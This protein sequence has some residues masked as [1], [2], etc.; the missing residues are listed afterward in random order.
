MINTLEKLAKLR[1]DVFSTLSYLGNSVPDGKIEEIVLGTYKSQKEMLEKI[2]DEEFILTNDQLQSIINDVKKD[3]YV[4]YVGDISEIDGK[5]KH[6]PW[7]TDEDRYNWKYFQRYKNR[8]SRSGLPPK[9][10]TKMDDWTDTILNKINNPNDEGSW[11]RRGLVVGHVQSGKTMN[12]IGLANK[13]LDKGYK[14]IIILAGRTNDLRSQ[15]QERC[16]LDI[17]GIDTEKKVDTQR[18]VP[19]GVGKDSNEKLNSLVVNYLTTMPGTKTSKNI[20]G[21][22]NRS[23]AKS[24]GMQSFDTLV[25]V[26]KKH[27]SILRDLLLWVQS[28]A[29]VNAPVAVEDTV[30]KDLKIK[31]INAFPLLLIDD[32]CDD[33]SVDSTK[34]IVDENNQPI[35]DHDPTKTNRLIRQ[36]LLSFSKSSYIGYTATP[37]AN[38]FIHHRGSSKEVGDDLFPR[39]FI[40]SLPHPDN[41]IGANEIF[42]S[43]NNYIKNI[44]DHALTSAKRE[45]N[46]WMP[47]KHD[48][49]H[50]PLYKDKLQCPPSLKEA[51]N[52]FVLATAGIKLRHY[53][54]PEHTSML[55]HV[56]RFRDVQEEV[57]QQVEDYFFELRLSV[58]NETDKD[59]NSLMK[60]LRLQWEDEFQKNLN[61]ENQNNYRKLKWE[62]IYNELHK[63]ISKIKL[64]KLN[65]D[66]DDYL[67]YKKNKKLGLSV[68]AIGGDRLSRGVTLEGLC[69]TYFLRAPFTHTADTLTQ[70]GRWY[71]YRNG[72]EDLCRVYM[73]NRMQRS[74]VSFAEF[75]NELR[76]DLELMETKGLT[77]EDFGFIV[78]TH[79]G[80]RVTG[81]SRNAKRI[82]LNY[83]GKTKQVRGINIDEDQNDFNCN[84]INKLYQD[85]MTANYSFKEE[86][87]LMWKDVES[88]FI[89]EFLESYKDAKGSNMRSDFNAKYIKHRLLETSRSELKKWTVVIRSGSSSENIK[90]D[91]FTVNLNIRSNRSIFDKPSRVDDYQ[92]TPATGNDQF[93]GLEEKLGVRGSDSGLLV[94][95]PIAY[96]KNKNSKE[97]DDLENKRFNAFMISY[98]ASDYNDPGFEMDVNSV[99]YMQWEK[100]MEEVS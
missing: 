50:K 5:E 14:F 39:D 17:F 77:P 61:E 91:N 49:T 1:S 41:Y 67:N 15:T 11:D 72:Y 16:D 42:L 75:E 76:K 99:S 9:I 3:K 81:K 70:M 57:R 48:K 18:I 4:D 63:D 66:S 46:G 68:I 37:Y 2:S 52:S 56:T 24:A 45:E 32:E 27:T 90:F 78:Q 95:Y 58:E 93:L 33:S 10:I 43:E 8:L 89:I 65:G 38:I 51:I 36:L 44:S 60:Q 94:I 12:Y 80:L 88:D 79:E 83:S 87:G 21:D 69:S 54:K 47:P 92:T 73:T 62:N 85:L 35:D 86:K 29:P 19:I 25:L 59:E 22:F 96:Q 100:E 84:L 30:I 7:L 71:G 26:V 82:K 23:I 53:G 31:K 34:G 97:N 74:Y 28:F 13:A 20:S 40:V 55:I 98:G 6:I 64:I